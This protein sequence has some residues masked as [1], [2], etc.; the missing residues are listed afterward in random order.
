[1]E[2]LSD[3]NDP[4]VQSLIKDVSIKVSLRKD[5]IFDIYTTVINGTIGLNVPFNV[6]INNLNVCIGIG[7]LI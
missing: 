2:F 7:T 6:H 5:I 1:M 3:P 4:L